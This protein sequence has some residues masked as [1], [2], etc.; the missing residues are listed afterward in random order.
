MLVMGCVPVLGQFV[1]DRRAVLGITQEELGVRVRRPQKWI[2]RL[3][4][5]L[6]ELP[7]PDTMAALAI[8]LE[9]PESD[10]TC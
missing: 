6:K 1:R 4:N 10:S 8:A 7:D 3:E 9:V 2:S 5:E